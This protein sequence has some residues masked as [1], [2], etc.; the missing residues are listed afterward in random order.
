[1]SEK[2]VILENL[3]PQAAGL[4]VKPSPFHPIHTLKEGPSGRFGVSRSFWAW[5]KKKKLT[6]VATKTEIA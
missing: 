6:T 4:H 5:E 3:Q 2:R 1:M